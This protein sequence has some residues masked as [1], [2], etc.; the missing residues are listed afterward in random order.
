MTLR[1][2]LNNIANTIYIYAN[3]NKYLKFLYSSKTDIKAYQEKKLKYII[4]IAVNKVPYYKAYKQ[5]IDF[6]NFSS[7]EL[8]KLPIVN[9]DIIKKNPLRF[10]REDKDIN[11]LRWKSTSGSSGKPFKTPKSYFSDAIEVI[12][13]YRAWSFG[14]NFYKLRSPAV[15]LRSFSPKEG[16]PIHKRDIIRNFW[17]ISPYHI[18]QNSLPIF[19]DVF[20]ESKAKVLKG[21]PS[22]IYILTLLLKKNNIKLN[23]IK[24]IITSSETMLQMYR[25]EIE[26]YWECDIL[27]WYGQNERTVTVQ[28]CSYGNYHNNDDYGICEIDG[29]N[30]IIA[31][32]LN[33]DIMPLLRYQT[34]DKA[35]PL[36]NEI[37]NCKCGS[38]MSIPFKG[39]LGRQDDIIYKQ[40]KKPIPTIN[41]YNL[42]EKF[43]N[44]KHFEVIQE[45]DLSVIVSIVEDRPLTINEK[46]NLENGLTERL[47]NIPIKINIVEEI[48]RNKKTDK[49][50]IIKSKVIL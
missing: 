49:M 30:N 9:K 6:N 3:Y 17:Y 39:I 26:K 1:N 40:G 11:K 15:V 41:F 20:K 35:I 14:E 7:N 46:L 38:L 37:I 32:S 36:E 18:N 47:G 13:S 44:I 2:T 19:L 48:L 25:L 24:T 16:K 8:Y 12:L 10:I 45:Q 28:Q 31:T 34:N 21:Y 50:K 43:Q 27:D 5:D 22:S 29:D 42:M 33:N 4:K 23:Q